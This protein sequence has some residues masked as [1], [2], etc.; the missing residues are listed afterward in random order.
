MSI[1][2]LTCVAIPGCPE[3]FGSCTYFHSEDVKFVH[4]LDQWWD[5]PW[6]LGLGLAL[7]RWLDN[8]R[9][10]WH[11][12]WRLKMNWSGKIYKL[13]RG[14]TA[15]CD[16]KTFSSWD[17]V[18]PLMP[19][20]NNDFK[21][22]L[23]FL[24]LGASWLSSWLGLLTPI[25]PSEVRRSDP[26]KESPQPSSLTLTVGSNPFSS[27]ESALG[28]DVGPAGLG[29]VLV[30][31][32]LGVKGDIPFMS[33]SYSE[34]EQFLIFKLVVSLE[35]KKYRICKKINMFGHESSTLRFNFPIR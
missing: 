19:L 14:D 12:K 1:L 34:T 16:V 33:R 29:D 27:P 25:F 2:E 17:T 20:V 10:G 9:Q 13:P 7:T 24:R 22:K 23:D 18:I 35:K 26:A 28:F 8:F 15:S 31:R 3:P 4:L 21:S 11:L 6:C 5:P 30:D 32:D